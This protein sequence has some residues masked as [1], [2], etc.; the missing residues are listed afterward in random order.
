LKQR[1][2]ITKTACVCYQTADSL[3][4]QPKIK[5]HHPLLAAAEIMA[6]LKNSTRPTA[7]PH[8]LDKQEITLQ[9]TLRR[10]EFHM[11]D[12]CCYA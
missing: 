4:L 9:P 6:G 2:S 7:Q 11:Y 10:K 8:S 12:M 1:P 3:C 5:K